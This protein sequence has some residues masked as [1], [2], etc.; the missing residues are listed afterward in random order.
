MNCSSRI[1]THTHPLSRCFR[2][3][4]TKRRVQR[5]NWRC[6]ALMSRCV[7]VPVPTGSITYHEAQREKSEQLV[8]EKEGMKDLLMQSERRRE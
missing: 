8:N 1:H 7:C 4:G 6:L 5:K 2:T 3:R